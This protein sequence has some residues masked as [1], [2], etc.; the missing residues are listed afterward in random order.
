MEPERPDL[1]PRGIANRRP[2]AARRKI[3]QRNKLGASPLPEGIA[4]A[5]LKIVPLDKAPTKWQMRDGTN[6]GLRP[7]SPLIDH[8]NKL[9][10]YWSPKSACTS[11]YVW[12]S[13]FAGFVDEVLRSGP[14]RHRTLIFNKSAFCAKGLETDPDELFAVKVLRNP[15]DRAVS[16]YRH[17]LV[18]GFAD[19][20]IR[21]AY[22]GKLTREE[23]FSFQKF[24][25]LVVKVGFTKSNPHYRPQTMRRDLIRKADYVINISKQDLF[26]ELNA[27]VASRGMPPVDLGK[28]NW[29]HSLESRRKAR[30]QPVEGENLDF[31]PFD[32]SAARGDKPFPTYEQLLTHSAK[33]RIR[34]IYGIDFETYGTHF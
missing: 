3:R 13:A 24:L 33:E 32:W 27:A 5:D 14:H 9:L 31:Q 19:D 22:G 4:L 2:G 20:D 28:I 6:L 23:G 26:S 17:A 7:S 29:L 15:Y 16:I 11:V 1:K 8:Q 12:F 30:T 21:S 25:D 18:T 34:E 10:I